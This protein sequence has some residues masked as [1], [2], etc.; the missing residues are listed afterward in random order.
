MTTEARYARLL[1]QSRVVN[2]EVMA[3]TDANASH[4]KMRCSQVIEMN[5]RLKTQEGVVGS[6]GLGPQTSTV[7][8]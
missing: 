5:E 2:R 3:Q 7:S 6:W 4:L 8:R 1:A